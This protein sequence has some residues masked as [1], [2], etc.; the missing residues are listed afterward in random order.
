GLIAKLEASQEKLNDALGPCDDECC[1]ETT[2]SQTC[3][4]RIRNL[5]ELM[6]LLE[7]RN[8]DQEILKSIQSSGLYLIRTEGVQAELQS[9]LAHFDISLAWRA[10]AQ[11]AMLCEPNQMHIFQALFYPFWPLSKHF[12]FLAGETST[13]SAAIEFETAWEYYLGNTITRLESGTGVNGH[14]LNQRWLADY[15]QVCCGV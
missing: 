11:I 15:A 4:R 12:K 3:K 1:W 8:V 2:P 6:K 9:D 5:S 14:L 10:V 7:E 13:V